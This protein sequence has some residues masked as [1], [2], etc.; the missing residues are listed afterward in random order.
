MGTGN[1]LFPV[2][3]GCAR[4]ANG[5]RGSRIRRA[6][7]G[8]CRAVTPSA[9]LLMAGFAGRAGC[10]DAWGCLAG[11]CAL[12]AGGLRRVDAASD[13]CARRPGCLR[14]KCCSS[15]QK[16]SELLDWGQAV[17]CG[18]R[19]LPVPGPRRVC[20]VCEWH[21]AFTHSVCVWWGCSAV[22]PS[23]RLLVGRLR[24]R[25]PGCGDARGCLA[26][27]DVRSA[28][29]APADGCRVGRVRTSAGLFCGRNVAVGD[30][31]VPQYRPGWGRAMGVATGD[32]CSLAQPGEGC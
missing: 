17:G 2:P 29:G 19:Q 22:T 10:G 12:G 14:K 21:E 11:G 16:C 23:A 3:I 18:D 32:P 5:M 26:G 9:R 1:C 6:C 30:G 8:G 4:C 13:G 27:A 20:A 24:R 15:W 28:P 25:A 31:N 7:G